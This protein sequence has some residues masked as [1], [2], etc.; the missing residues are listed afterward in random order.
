LYE[1]LK[2]RFVNA[3]NL[4]LL[5]ADA[6]DHL[7]AKAAEFHDWKL[8][9][10]LPFSV[11]SPILVELSLSAGRPRQMVATLQL[12]VVQR[13]AARPG[14]GDY[15]VLTLLVQLDYQSAGWFK[16]PPGSFFP[17][18]AVDSACINLRR[19]AEPLVSP[20]ERI[21]FVRLVK[22]G[23]SQRRK[24]LMKLLKQQWPAEKLAAAF[25]ALA[26]SPQARAETLSLEQFIALVRQ[27]NS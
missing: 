17:A 5:H 24:M 26:I 9:A 22:L 12:E 11:A 8:V 16:I 19:R 4:T 27:L 7:K 18:P 25:A 20:E 2:G 13:L 10:N 15:G 1:F 21:K 14:T 3:K 6:L 23:F